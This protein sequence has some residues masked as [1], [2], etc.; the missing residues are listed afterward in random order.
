VNIVVV[1]ILFR[2]YY[3]EE[4]KL[5]I[6]RKREIEMKIADLTATKNRAVERED[7]KVANTLKVELELC[8]DELEEKRRYISF[9]ESL[10]L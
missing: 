4:K 1:F 8:D 3:E 7:F 10:I 6:I 2:A 9:V 5:N